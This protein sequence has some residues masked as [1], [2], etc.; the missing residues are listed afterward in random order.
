MQI[1]KTSILILAATLALALAVARGCWHTSSVV[2]VISETTAQELW[3]GEHAGAARAAQRYGWKLYWNGPSRIE[4]FP[5]QLQIVRRV[6]A[7]GVRALI[8][9]P[10]HDVVLVSAVREALADKIPVVV[11]GTPLA[12]VP[13]NGL[14]YVLNDDQMTGRMAAEF[15]AH[16]LKDGDSV[17]VL[18]I[19]PNLLGSVQKANAFEE[20]MAT[21]APNAHIEEHHSTSDSAAETE[22]YAEQRV[23]A[24][25]RIRFILAL[26]VEQTR[27]GYAALINAGAEKRV[28]LIGCGQDLDLLHHLRFGVTDAIIAED[29]NRMGEIAVENVHHQLAGEPVAASV[30]VKPVLVTRENIDSTDVQRVLSMDWR[31]QP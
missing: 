1:P 30:L 5:G 4:D 27:A 18:G 28:H 6:L 15:A 12:M 14:T 29:T 20:S 2:A 23:R 25:A 10:D 24:D 31:V 21:L 7:R 9:S 3:E 26:D 17:L 19:N 13:G 8:L 22:D 16:Q 11:V